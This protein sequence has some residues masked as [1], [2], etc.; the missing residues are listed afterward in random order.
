MG[1]FFSGLAGIGKKVLGGTSGGGASEGAAAETS[2]LQRHM[3][4][5][6]GGLGSL[7]ANLLDQPAPQPRKRLP[8]PAPVKPLGVPAASPEG[9]LSS[10]PYSMPGAEGGFAT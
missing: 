5:L 8:L 1:A 6:A 10:T 3:G 9:S 4:G 2:G 7:S